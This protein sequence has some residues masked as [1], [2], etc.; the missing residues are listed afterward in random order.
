[1]IF[2]TTISPSIKFS[3]ITIGLLIFLAKGSNNPRA[4]ASLFLFTINFTT[5]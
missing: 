5:A 3:K 2:Y 1:M 4:I